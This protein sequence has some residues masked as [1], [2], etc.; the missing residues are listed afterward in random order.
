MVPHTL[1]YT[2]VTIYKIDF[3]ATRFAMLGVYISKSRKSIAEVA[4][5][6]APAGNLCSLEIWAEFSGRKGLIRGN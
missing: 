5:G 1:H 3:A 6:S 2:N 4:G